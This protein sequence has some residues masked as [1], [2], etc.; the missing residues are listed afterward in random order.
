MSYIVLACLFVASDVL[1]T[2]VFGKFIGIHIGD[3]IN[4]EAPAG[5]LI[6]P[7]TFLISDIITEVYNKTYAKRVVLAS[8]FCNF[9]VVMLLQI[10]DHIPAA[11]ISSLSNEEF[12]KVFNLSVSAFCASSVA[13]L[14][15]QLLDIQIYHTL[16]KWTSGRLMWMRNFLSVSISQ[17]VDTAIFFSVLLILGII[18][19]SVFTSIFISTFSL[20]VIWAVVD[21]PFFYIGVYLL[22]YINSTLSEDHIKNAVQLIQSKQS[23]SPGLAK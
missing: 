22:R 18:S 12:H 5:T 2:I 7:I 4:I 13:Y 8:F 1:A 6:Y 3:F 11:S 20:K 17:L 16:K 21:I 10:I 15:S 14:A 9:F 23:N 19:K